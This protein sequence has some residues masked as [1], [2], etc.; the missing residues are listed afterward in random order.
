MALERLHQMEANKLAMV[1]VLERQRAQDR[2]T[3]RQE[4][5]ARDSPQTFYNNTIYFST[6]LVTFDASPPTSASAPTSVHPSIASPEPA[7]SASAKSSTDSSRNPNKPRSSEEVMAL[8][9]KKEELKWTKEVER[10]ERVE[11]AVEN[12]RRNQ[13]QRVKDERERVEMQSRNP[14]GISQLNSISDTTELFTSHSGGAFRA[15]VSSIPTVDDDPSLYRPA[16]NPAASHQQSKE[17]VIRMTRRQLLKESQERKG[18]EST[19]SPPTGPSQRSKNLTA[20]IQQAKLERDRL[21]AES[22]LNA[23]ARNAVAIDSDSNRMGSASSS[24]TSNNHSTRAPDPPF[25]STGYA[26]MAPSHSSPTTLST[27]M[28]TSTSLPESTIT[29]PGRYSAVSPPPPP[30]PRKLSQTIAKKKPINHNATMLTSSFKGTG[31]NT[32]GGY[33]SE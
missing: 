7:I 29:K 16:N 28:S 2:E 9:R 1:Q 31:R 13:L 20:Q 8:K 17:S 5:L 12:N 6:N 24:S 10:L 11:L 27:S 3:R 26:R 30:Q 33:M 4:L 25:L 21:N 19:D 23:I 14:D 32:P 22:Q 18:L 15:K